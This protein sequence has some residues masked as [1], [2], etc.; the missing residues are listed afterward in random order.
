MIAF[1]GRVSGR[2][3][4]EV[5]ASASSSHNYVW[6]TSDRETDSNKKNKVL[7]CSVGERWELGEGGS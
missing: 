4:E 7:V 2:G 6:W 1:K 5:S 3:E